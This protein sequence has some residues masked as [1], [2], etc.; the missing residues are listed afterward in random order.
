MQPLISRNP[1]KA[2][3]HCAG[4]SLIEAVLVIVVIGVIG[5][6][7]T[8]FLLSP[9]SGYADTVRRLQL[10]EQADFA[11]RRMSRDLGG[12]LPNSVR[13][14]TSG[15]DSILEFLNVRSAARYC[16]GASCGGPLFDGD[17]EFAWLSPG[18]LSVLAGD[19]IVVANG[20]NSDCDAYATSPNNRRTVGSTSSNLITFGGAAFNSSCKESTR[21]FFV[22]DGPVTYAC[23]AASSTLWRYSGYSIQPAIASS[24]NDLN[25]LLGNVKARVATDVQCASTIFNVTALTENLVELRIQLMSSTGEKVNLYRQVRLEQ[26]I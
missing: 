6:G 17:N 9:V 12:A 11:L 24:I 26:A 14:T 1:E 3:V 4:M 21:R 7:L 23:E 16:N 19:F 5:T 20:V 15:Q 2:F 10:V 18:V 22:V 25:L 13:T 8:V